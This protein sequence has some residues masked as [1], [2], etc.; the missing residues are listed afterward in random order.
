MLRVWVHH[1]Q[2]SRLKQEGET[3]DMAVCRHEFILQFFCIEGLVLMLM[4]SS[5]QWGGKCVR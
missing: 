4:M 2:R 1:F 3:I 5:L